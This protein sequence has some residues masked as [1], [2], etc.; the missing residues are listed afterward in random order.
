MIE[1]STS[2][3]FTLVAIAI[4][5]QSPGVMA[6][7]DE[8]RQDK[9]GHSLTSLGKSKTDSMPAG[10]VNDA[11]LHDG[12]SPGSPAVSAEADIK[13]KTDELNQVRERMKQV[14]AEL[15]TISGKRDKLYK[16]LSE[17]E[18]R[19]GEIALSI[20]QLEPLIVAQQVK[21]KAL[22]GERAE[23]QKQIHQHQLRLVSQVRAAHAMGRQQRL[24]LV[25]NQD[26][27]DRTSRQLV[28]YTYFNRARLSKIAAVNQRIEALRQVENKL[29]TQSQKLDQLYNSQRVAQAELN[30]ARQQQQ[31]LVNAIDQKMKQH[32]SDL[33]QLKRDQQRLKALIVSIQKALNGL[34]SITQTAS[35]TFRQ[36]RGSLRWPVNGRL[37]EQFGANQGREYHGGVLINAKE[38]TDV[39]AIAAGRV[40]YADWLRGYGLLTI[41]DHGDGFMTLYAF[42]QALYRGVGEL[43]NAGDPVAAVGLSGGR[44]QPG[45]YFGIRLKGKPVNPT[46]WCRK[47]SKGL[48]DAGSN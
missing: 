32:G 4:L 29:L 19:Y 27:P 5:G 28:Y 16:A 22:D 11:K 15:K 2:I 20:H 48:V 14:Q 1:K 36:Q 30:E 12:V 41:I 23:E 37:L 7:A 45:L 13:L 25:L 34:P 21:L 39:A 47:V 3:R 33:K 38:G 43:V 35:L 40:L 6:E 9:T 31:Q 42:N 44:S 10:A 8:K 18:L 46:E 17:T 24:K 26:R